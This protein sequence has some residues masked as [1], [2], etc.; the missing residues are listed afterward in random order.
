LCQPDDVHVGQPHEG[1]VGD[2][3]GELHLPVDMEEA[4]DQPL[5]IFGEAGQDL[6]AVT[7]VEALYVARHCLLVI[8]HVASSKL[9]V[10]HDDAHATGLR[11][12]A[13]GAPLARSRK[14]PPCRDTTDASTRGSSA[15]PTWQPRTSVR[16]RG[17]TER[18]SAGSSALPVRSSAV[19]ASRPAMGSR[20]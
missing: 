4:G 20:P 5:D 14:L 10:L 19:T 17:S 2:L 6:L 9:A 1:V 12:R 18:Y 16:R 8:S 11:R 13:S 7:L 3:T 15:G